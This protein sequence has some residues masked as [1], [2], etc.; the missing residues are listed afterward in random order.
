MTIAEIIIIGLI[1]FLIISYY[2]GSGTVN[3][4]QGFILEKIAEL[5]KEIKQLKQK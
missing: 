3:C 4:N 2:I 5:K 1:L